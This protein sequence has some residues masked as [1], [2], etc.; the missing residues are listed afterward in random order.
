MRFLSHSLFAFFLL[1]GVLFAQTDSRFMV[2]RHT[3]S[4]VPITRPIGVGQG[5]Q[6]VTVE[7]VDAIIRIEDRIATT[8]LVIALHNPHRSQLEAQMILP[9]PAGAVLKGHHFDGLPG[10]P[11]AR[12]LPKDEARKIYDVIVASTL[13]PALLEFVG[14]DL[15]QSS[16]FPV[17]AGGRQKVELT[18]EQLLPIDG[19][20]IEY[21]LPRS[22]ALEYRIPWTYQVEVHGGKGGKIASVYSP[23]HALSQKRRQA[24]LDC[25][26][27]SDQPGPF[28]LSVLR[29][30][31]K[32]LTASLLAYPDPKVGGG[33][34]MLLAVPPA[35]APE[36]AGAKKFKREVTL[37]IDRSGSMA[38]EKLDQAR[39]AALQV[40]EGLEDGEA[41]NIILYNES[42][43]AFSD[44]PVVS[45]RENVKSARAYLDAMRVSGGTNIH[46][47]LVEALR[48]EP[49]EEA[50]PIVLFLTDG[51]PTV[52]QTSERAIREAVEKGNPHQRRIFTFGVGI[53]VNTPLLNRVARMTR[54][55]STFVLPQEDVE[56]KVGGVFR[57]LAG[58]AFANPTLTVLGGAEE[59]GRVTDL[60]P[61]ELP[62]LFAGEQLVLLGR[63]I[64]DAPLRFQFAGLTANGP[65]KIE[66]RFALKKATTRNAF[67]SRLWA[68][69]KIGVMTEAIR[70]L[71]ADT[72][73]GTARPNLAD[74]KVKEMVDEIVRL[75]RE[76]G[77]LTEYTAFLAEEGT[78][79]TG[80]DALNE[81]ARAN[82]S[83]R[84]LQSRSGLGGYNQE[85]NLKKQIESKQ[86]NRDN[87]FFDAEL[88]KVTP[89]GIQQINDKTYWKR[90]NVWCDGRVALEPTTPNS[91]SASGVALGIEPTPKGQ[92]IAGKAAA[93][94]FDPN[95]GFAPDRVVTVGTPEF[96]VVV[97]QLVAENRQGC[98]ALRG[99]ILVRVG[100]ENIL[101]R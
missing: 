64:G 32:G 93:A 58:P 59:L 11:S 16:V 99:E 48:Q 42:V 67:V 25:S 101:I 88:S 65:R 15:V 10:E 46:D 23:S 28:L 51:L 29:E 69:H 78:Q 31:K 54:A 97:D 60:L 12:I 22:E 72:L 74:P 34:F 1:G 30:S 7:K 61:S 40:I 6:Q 50:L 53:D 71:G 44:R 77:I 27:K 92:T 66:H 86:L 45:S 68:N 62:D 8:R 87:G 41:F 100:Q 18:W 17:P 81:E 24:A 5:R 63:Y 89:G 91:S 70:D 21:Q 49:F 37:V 57:R 19:D 36:D 94:Q 38:G 90:G 75:S 3:D 95:L 96:N 13:D 84:A 79:L 52:G 26:A 2:T 39:A 43:E 98:L 47:A 33:Y 9:V 80:T 83:A 56:V 82:Y 14:T 35:D 76:F 4:I 73:Y 55:T 85:A 20:R